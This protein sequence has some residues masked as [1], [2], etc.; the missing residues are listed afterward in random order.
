MLIVQEQI[1]RLRKKEKLS[2][3][4]LAE[5]LHLTRQAISSWERGISEPDLDSLTQISKL[6]QISLDELINGGDQREDVKEQERLQKGLLVGILFSCCFALVVIVQKQDL[7]ILITLGILT[8][9][10]SVMLMTFGY[11]IRHQDYTMLAGYE[12]ET[13]YHT[14]AV[15]KMLIAMQT[16]ILIG[17]G[18][19]LLLN[20][21]LGFLMEVKIIYFLTM[22]LFILHMFSSILICNVR[23]RQQ[24]FIQEKDRL[25]A[26]ASLPS[27]LCFLMNIMFLVL[28]AVVCFQL[29]DIHNN[30]SQAMII[31][32]IVLFAALLNI[33][34]LFYAQRKAKNELSF[35][36]LWTFLLLLFNLLAGAI[37]LLFPS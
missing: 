1:K 7:S 8:I 36:K 21:I 27:L 18:I 28:I 9:M 13:A 4:E 32:S 23:Y 24:L 14:P 17:Y 25:I 22:I 19:A 20:L 33:V 26:K 2:Q 6:F 29:H 30:S 15:N 34:W 12:D 31:G 37:L 3:Q 16:M 35:P 11:A 10:T 5:Q